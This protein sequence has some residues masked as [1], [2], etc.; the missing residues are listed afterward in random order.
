MFPSLHFQL[1]LLLQLRIPLTS[2]PSVPLVV[3]VCAKSVHPLSV[4]S[5]VNIKEL[6]ITSAEV[7][8]LFSLKTE[9]HA[10]ARKIRN[11]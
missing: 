2:L 5:V 3:S 7:S 10:E 1:P 4:Y 9:S 6:L 11:S 8:P